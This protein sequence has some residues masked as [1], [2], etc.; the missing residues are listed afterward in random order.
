MKNDGF[1]LSRIHA[2]GWVAARTLWKPG[3]PPVNPYTAEPEQS[4]WQEGFLSAQTE[5]KRT[6][7]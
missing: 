2:E 6:S 4:R 5:P 3:H 7:S 1:R